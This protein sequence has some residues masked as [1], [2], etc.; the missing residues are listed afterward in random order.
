[1]YFC[2]LFS[3]SQGGP[4]ARSCG[5]C[6]HGECV[7]KGLGESA[8]LRQAFT[9]STGFR[10]LRALVRKEADERG[11]FLAPTP[12]CFNA[13]HDESATSSADEFRVGFPCFPSLCAGKRDAWLKISTGV[14]QHQQRASASWARQAVAND[15][16][17]TGIAD[18]NSF[19]YCHFDAIGPC[20][21]LLCVVSVK[22]F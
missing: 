14:R 18:W 4:G 21:R 10:V 19:L 3:R 13:K 20:A 11:C 1:M 7:T 8:P 12:P 5:R 22:R 9:C 15:L 16:D 6:Q 2:H 17:A